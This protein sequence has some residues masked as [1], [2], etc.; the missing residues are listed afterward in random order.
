MFETAQAEEARLTSQIMA[1]LEEHGITAGFGALACGADILVAETLLRRSAEL[2]VLLPFS[3]ER[4]AE[5]SVTIGGKGW[6]PR[7][8]DCLKRATSVRT[9]PMEPDTNPY[10]AA[11][12]SAMAAALAQD[13]QALQISLFDGMDADSDVG[14]GSDIAHWKSLGGRTIIIPTGPNLRLPQM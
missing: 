2:H 8:Q 12:Q 9:I 11:S 13:P 1:C 6:L 3:P 5:T 14:T 7:Y 4:F 10:V